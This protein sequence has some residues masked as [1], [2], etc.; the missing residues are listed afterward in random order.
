[1]SNGATLA[2]ASGVQYTAAESLTLAG[3]GAAGWNGAVDL[4]GDGAAL[5][6]GPITLSDDATLGCSSAN[7]TLTLS[8]NIAGTNSVQKNGA[9]LLVL[10]GSNSF[11][12]LTI[13][14]GAVLASNSAA[15]GAAAGT[16][17]VHNTGQLKLSSSITNN[18][19]IQLEGATSGHG[20]LAECG[21]NQ[22]AERT[23]WFAGRRF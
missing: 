9:G 7:G 13:N 1:M 10:G 12:G 20:S 14:A 21:R 16:V 3:D 11:V 19:P 5:F 15:L 6:A 8:G 2:F 18:N 22:P 23:R 4:E 17:L